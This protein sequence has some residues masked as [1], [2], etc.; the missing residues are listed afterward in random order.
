VTG[1]RLPGSLIVWRVTPEA[2]SI[3]VL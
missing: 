3:A 1:T 2:V